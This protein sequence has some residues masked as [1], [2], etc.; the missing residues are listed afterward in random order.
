MA[1]EDGTVFRGEAVGAEGIAFGEAVFTTAMTGYQETVTDPSYA[2]Q[3][4]CF[5]A[6][7]IGNYGVSASR[8][9]SAGAHAK[10]VLMREARGPE[11]TA[12]LAE[13]GIVGITGIDTRSLVLRLRD[14]GAMRAVAVAGDLGEEEA[15]AAVHAQPRMDGRSLVAQVSTKEQYLFSNHSGEARVTVAVVDYGC[16]RSIL[17]RLAAAGARVEVYPY[18][19]G[20]D[21]LAEHDAVVLSNG[22]GDPEPLREEVRTVE[23]LLGRVPILGICLG[24][25]LLGLATGH[26]T[27]K[28][29][30]GHR[31]ANHP[32][33]ERTTGR[34][35]VTSQNHGFAVAPTDAREAT[36]V[37]LYD[38]TVEGFD[39]PELR[40]RSAQFHPEAGPGPHDGWPILERW[41]DEVKCAS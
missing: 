32:V 35:L 34:V 41:L 12:W 19:T 8:S 2:E 25:Q 24:H 30:F 40:A 23:E 37:S 9:E 21:E 16:K 38:G 7:M 36:H 22:P 4:V 20:A 13:R 28:L 11:W 6:P 29:P 39:F 5:T 1:L 33:L 3:L 10:A 18:T 17:R 14:A 31:G 26:D 15:L 27:F